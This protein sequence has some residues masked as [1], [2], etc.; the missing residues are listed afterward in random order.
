MNI[1]TRRNGSGTIT[2]KISSAETPRARR[3]RTWVPVVAATFSILGLLATLVV[4][5]V[6][7]RLQ[8]FVEGTYDT[9][10]S[11]VLKRLDDHDAHF[12]Q[13]DAALYQMNGS[14]QRIEGYL[15]GSRPVPRRNSK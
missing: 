14:L 4:Y 1:L 15:D 7:P 5:S 9:K 3:F 13:Q 11:T 6:K 12:K 2:G 10:A 8:D